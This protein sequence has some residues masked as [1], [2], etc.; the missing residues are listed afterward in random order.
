MLPNDVFGT[1]KQEMEETE[2]WVSLAGALG[3]CDIHPFRAS[4]D[5]ISSLADEIKRDKRLLKA[6]YR[7]SRDPV[8]AEDSREFNDKVE[9]L[10]QTENPDSRMDIMV[11]LLI[12]IED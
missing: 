12:D 4:N 1:I 5:E 6:F 7:G 11:N 3:A 9:E 10:L 8:F 2:D